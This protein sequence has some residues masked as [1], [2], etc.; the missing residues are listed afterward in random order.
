MSAPAYWSPGETVLW[1]YTNPKHPTETVRPVRVV[2]DDA[3]GLVAWLAA[4]T[5]L[6]RPVLADGSDLRTV[7]VAERFDVEGHGRANRLGVW[8]GHGILKVAPAGAPW[9]VWLFWN[10]DGFRGWYVNLE[11]VHQRGDHELVTQDH[12]LDVVVTPDR[13]VRRKDE[14]ELAAAVTVGRFTAA[15]AAA[16]EQDAADVEDVVR[17]WGPPFCAGWESWA[18]DPAWPL[19]QLPPAY[20]ESAAYR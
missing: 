15:E 1:R 10:D 17:R 18:A 9:S 7:P 11:S 3:D 6:L 19:P 5:P 20:V 12:V 4:G 14:D 8:R 2:R 16:F 13:E